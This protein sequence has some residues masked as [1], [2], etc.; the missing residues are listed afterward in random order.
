MDEAKSALTA[1]DV[2][3]GG[4]RLA[5]SSPSDIGIPLIAWDRLEALACQQDGLRR[6]ATLVA[7]G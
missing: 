1:G 2:R 7:R 3:N 5:F 6:V 4:Y